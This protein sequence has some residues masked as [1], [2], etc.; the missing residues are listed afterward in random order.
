[1]EQNKLMSKPFKQIFHITDIKNNIIGI[2]FITKIILTINIL[3]NK[4]HKKDK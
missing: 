3:N 4:S 1:M 2:S